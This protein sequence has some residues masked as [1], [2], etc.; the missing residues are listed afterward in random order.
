MYGAKAEAI[1]KAAWA[2]WGNKGEAPEAVRRAIVE[3]VFLVCNDETKTDTDL[4]AVKGFP[5]AL[6]HDPFVRLSRALANNPL[7]A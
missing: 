1:A 7:A 4:Q 2:T 6:G 3:G 5:K